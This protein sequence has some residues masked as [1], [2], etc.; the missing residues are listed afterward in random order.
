MVQ[1]DKSQMKIQGVGTTKNIFSPRKMFFIVVHIPAAGYL[2]KQKSSGRP[3]TAEDDVEQI[4]AS[5]LHSPRK[6]TGT[7]AK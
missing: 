7:A 4:G 6:S 1:H 2:C 5:F 3:L